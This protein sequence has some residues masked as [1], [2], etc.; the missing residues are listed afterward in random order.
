MD[1]ATT[2]TATMVP[3]TEPKKH[4]HTIAD[5]MIGCLLGE[6][7]AYQVREKAWRTVTTANIPD[8]DLKAAAGATNAMRDKYAMALAEEKKRTG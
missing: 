3:T 7:N 8:R 4:F 1:T 5:S 6:I 2:T